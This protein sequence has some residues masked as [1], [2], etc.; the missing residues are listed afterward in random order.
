MRKSKT[1]ARFAQG[2][3][4]RVCNLGHF[5]PSYVAHAAR[6]GYDC[7][8]LD[9]EHRAMSTREVQA[10]LVQC[11]LY[12]ID[13][14]LR[15]PTLEKT[16]LYRYLEDGAAGLMIPHVSTVE[17]AQQLVAAVKFPPVG[18]RGLDNAGLDSDYLASYDHMAYTQAANAET[19]LTV[20]IE[21]PEAVENCEAIIALEGVDAVFVGPGD[22]GFRLALAGDKTGAQLESAI[23]K[24]A[25][26]C[27][28]YGK[29]W[30]CPASTPDML[31]RRREQGAQL[32]CNFGEFVCLMQGLANASQAFDAL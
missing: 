30:G 9:L 20:Q 13:C 14:L 24:V 16:R 23:E 17:M 10:I 5:I 27:A 12:D 22:L 32:L 29:A 8:W 11:H 21:T 18:N 31:K 25:A 3:V 2:E 15:P 1:V 26:A 28:K 6:A 4:V 7:I 19:F